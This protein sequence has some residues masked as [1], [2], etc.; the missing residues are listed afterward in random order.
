M[1]LR[2]EV[3]LPLQLLQSPWR[4]T[5]F[6]AAHVHKLCVSDSPVTFIELVTMSEIHLFLSIFLTLNSFFPQTL[7][8]LTH[9]LTFAMTSPHVLFPLFHFTFTIHTKS[10]PL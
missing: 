2:K 4:V 7:I 10:K 5:R 3:A 9:A 1:G 6:D 8:L